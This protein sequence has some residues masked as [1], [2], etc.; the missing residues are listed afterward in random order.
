[1][2]QLES[3]NTSGYTLASQVSRT[4]PCMC[5]MPHMSNHHVF[6]NQA[7]STYLTACRH[8]CYRPLACPPYAGIAELLFQVRWE[9]AVRYLALCADSAY[10]AMVSMVQS[11]GPA[12]HL[13]SQ[14]AAAQHT[15]WCQCPVLC[16]VI[17][18]R[19]HHMSVCCA[20]MCCIVCG[21]G[22]RSNKGDQLCQCD[23]GGGHSG[24]I[25]DA[26]KEACQ[27]EAGQQGRGMHVLHSVS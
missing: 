14:L 18:G 16:P 6:Q 21:G 13:L 26:A 19:K 8:A 22:C 27:H 20:G 4:G 5:S 9:G 11:T 15:P 23:A 7:F 2:V 3:R 12:C 24:S 1:M 17:T 10:C 25:Q